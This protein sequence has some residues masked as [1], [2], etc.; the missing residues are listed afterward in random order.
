MGIESHYKK[1]I[2]KGDRKYWER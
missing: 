2:V 1:V